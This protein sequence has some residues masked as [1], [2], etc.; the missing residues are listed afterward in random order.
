M[1]LLIRLMICVA[2][3]AGVNITASHSR[4]TSIDTGQPD[5]T[6]ITR[7]LA[8][9][10][11]EWL[12]FGDEYVRYAKLNLQVFP[13]DSFWMLQYPEYNLI[14]VIIKN[15]SQKPLLLKRNEY[16]SQY[17]S[18]VVALDHL[19]AQYALL[20]RPDSYASNC[21][22]LGVIAAMQATLLGFGLID[23]KIVRRV[24]VGGT[25]FVG[26]LLVWL[27]VIVKKM[28]R[29][30]VKYRKLKNLA[31]VLKTADGRK[32]PMD[33][34]DFY[35]IPPHTTFIDTLIVDQS[36][37]KNLPHV[38]QPHKVAPAICF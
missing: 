32:T 1:K 20:A 10:E 14:E 24:A 6:C 27:S 22:A 25:L 34:S 31:P 11:K 13:K 37:V 35:T 9:H 28:R 2:L 33:V 16:L 38:P 19:L 21:A 26:A 8:K 36:S 23:D 4:Y 30:L 15:D 5:V 7:Q 12:L 3:G 17:K 29:C 18:H